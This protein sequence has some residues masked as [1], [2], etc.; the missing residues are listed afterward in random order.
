[1]HDRNGALWRAFSRLAGA[2]QIYNAQSL[3]L[4]LIGP[5]V[6]RGLPRAP[7]AGIAPSGGPED[8][9]HISALAVKGDLTFAAVGAHVVECKR[10]HRTGV[11]SVG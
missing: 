10:V 8:E 11:Y 2:M 1:M 9:P 5:D 7:T 3:R 6:T 4:R